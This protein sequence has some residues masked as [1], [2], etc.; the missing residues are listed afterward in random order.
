MHDPSGFTRVS[1]RAPHNA[2]CRQDR[3]HHRVFNARHVGT[4]L[5]ARAGC[6][7]E[8]A[9]GTK[10][11]HDRGEGLGNGERRSGHGL[12]DERGGLRVFALGK[13]P[14]D[15]ARRPRSVR[16]RAEGA[17]CPG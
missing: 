12:V 14:H 10:A 6:R 4:E 8:E 3:A 7:L 9:L 17:E 15:R 1:V 5:V 2:R 13:R 11:R 16:T